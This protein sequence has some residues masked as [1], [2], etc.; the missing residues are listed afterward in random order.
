MSVFHARS[1]D[2]HEDVAF[3]TDSAS[4]LKAIIAIH[5]NREAGALGGCRLWRY[6][7]EDEALEDVLR[8]SRAMTYKAVMADLPL[9]G[10]KAVILED[11]DH[12]KDEALLRAMG[13]FIHSLNGRYISSEDVGI[14]VTD[15]RVICEETPHVVGLAGRSGDPSPVTAKG[16]FI[17][18]LAGTRRA[19]RRTGLEGTT[20]ALQG[21]G[22]VGG[23]LCELLTRAGARVLVSDIVEER[24]TAAVERFGV[25]PVPMNRILTVEADI[26]APCALGGVIG[27]HNVGKLKAKIVAGAANNQLSGLGVA[28]RLKARGI[29]YAPDFVVNAGGLLNVATERGLLSAASVDQRLERIADTLERIFDYADTRDLSTAAAAEELARARLA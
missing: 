13:R 18:I 15:A 11:P 5:K 10:A 7:R 21:L 25:T 14:S 19:L 8:L 28:D 1:F 9:G 23:A 12:P 17:G 3:H 24:V 29:L 2:C 22:K 16:V 4:G 20:V 26:L 6:N 27:E